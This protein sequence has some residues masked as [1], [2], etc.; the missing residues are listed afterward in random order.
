MAA[1]APYMMHA[2]LGG[3]RW[4]QIAWTY[5]GDPTLISPII[6]ANPS[7]PIVAA[8]DPGTQIMVPLLEQ[9]QPVASELP[10]WETL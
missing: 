1:S 2:A 8:L 10:P 7:V 5:Y 4:D 6:M 9:S 3:E